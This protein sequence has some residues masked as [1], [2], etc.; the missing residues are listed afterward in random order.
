MQSLELSM[1]REGD[2]NPRG[3]KPSHAFQACT[4]DRSAISPIYVIVG[5]VEDF[6][7]L[8]LRK[9]QRFR[10]KIADRMKREAVHVSSTQPSLQ[11]KIVRD[12]IP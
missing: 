7:H 11:Y 1:R 12:I 2:S 9:H 4:F 5:A 3:R 6:V 10:D 8:S